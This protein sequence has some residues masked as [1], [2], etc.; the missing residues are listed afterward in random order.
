M[1][2]PFFGLQR[3]PFSIAPDPHFLFM[4]E[5]HREALAH[6]LY[7][8]AGGGGFVLLT[9]EIGAGKTTVCRCFLDQVPAHCDVAYVF[10]PKLSVTELLQTVCDEFGIQV[11]AGA[12]TIKGFVDPLNDFLLRSHA[13]GRH[14]VLIIDEAQ[15][16]SAELL[17]QLRLLTNLE[18]AERK[19]LQI[20]LIGQP[21]LREMLARPDLEQLAQRVL[22]RYHLPA[23]T[24]G[25]TAQYVR[26]RLAVAGLAGEMPFDARALR[27]LH[28]LCGGVPRRINL[29][30]DRA[31]LGAYAG[32]KGRVDR[33]IVEQAARE[34]F[35]APR[36]PPRRPLAAAWGAIAVTAAA[37]GIV[38][39]WQ[40]PRLPAAPVVGGSASMAAAASPAASAA[41]TPLLAA[42]AATAASAAATTDAGELLARSLRSEALAW[43]ELAPL[44]AL[45]LPEGDPCEAA[46]RQ[47]IACFRSSS[48]L[49]QVR[50]L[51][52]P[53]ILALRD[54]QDRPLYALLIGLSA[55]SATFSAGGKPLVVPLALLAGLW[56]GD[57][58][59]FWRAPPG[60]REP[61]GEAANGPLAE[62][63][64]AH[65]S[66]LPGQPLKARV[67]AFQ[68]AHGLKPDGLPG[69]MTLMQ[70][71]RA[72][73][74][75]E[76]RLAN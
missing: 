50:E 75:D 63:V 55:D 39:A 49:A 10:N 53:G 28:E 9:G 72:S 21:E 60:Y 61:P 32:G 47:Q 59:T 5:A 35:G 42:S 20:V 11:P 56:R 38:Y 23:L 40:R 74:I 15:S 16:L 22:A 64:G 52:R 30:A 19:L 76:P 12:A 57:F 27:R 58:A 54:A 33:G 46:L 31:L 71:N 29:L 25:E 73:G 66:G 37:A 34:V 67:V 26:H 70:I 43:R 17:E 65:L 13:A 18:T 1:Y 24:E 14:S 51:G 36:T 4:S 6:L 44:W 7:G 69:P 8:L 45:N 62:W 68:V 41:S 2:A 3:E 48:G